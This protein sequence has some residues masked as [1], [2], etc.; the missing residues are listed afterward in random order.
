MC[1][2]GI[3]KN[4]KT[5]MFLNENLNISNDSLMIDIDIFNKHFKQCYGNYGIKM[6]NLGY[7]LL[8][9]IIKNINIRALY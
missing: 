6:N 7:E 2:K 5:I 8:I 9:Y 4:Q 1:D 3:R